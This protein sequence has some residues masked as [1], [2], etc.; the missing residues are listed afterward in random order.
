[1]N[2]DIYKASFDLLFVSEPEDELL[3]A[4]D[5]DDDDEYLRD[6]LL[7]CFFFDFLSFIFDTFDDVMSY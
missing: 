6:F 3:L 1:M 2:I 4:D 7:L 5:Y